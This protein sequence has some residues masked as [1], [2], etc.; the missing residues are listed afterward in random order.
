MSEP[1]YDPDS[2]HAKA[3]RWLL[4]Y[5][6]EQFR[7]GVAAGLQVAETCRTWLTQIPDTDRQRYTRRCVEAG[8]AEACKRYGLE[9]PRFA[10][11]PEKKMP[12]NEARS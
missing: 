6:R 8:I 4:E 11:M 1:F 2:T 10:P 7:E 9:V 12:E 3:E 5:G